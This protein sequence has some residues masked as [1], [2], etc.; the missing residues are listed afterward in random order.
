MIPLAMY[1][2]SGDELGLWYVFQSLGTAAILFDFGFNPSFA[3]NIAYCWSG[4]SSLSKRGG[5]NAELNEVNFV[6]LKK[7]LVTCRKIYLLIACSALFLCLTCGVGYIRFITASLNN[8]VYMTSWLIYSAAIFMN[9]YY[10]YFMSFLRGVGAIKQVNR[11]M[12]FARITQVSAMIILLVLGYGILAASVSYFLYGTLFRIIAQREFFSYQR[13]GIQLNSVENHF[14]YV[15]IWEMFHVIWYNTWRAGVVLF[16]NYLSN[17]ASTIIC[18]LFFTLAETGSY[19][20][21]VQLTSAVAIISSVAYTTY[22]PSLQA[23]YITGNSEKIRRDMSLIVVSYIM[24]FIIGIVALIVIGMPLFSMVK[25]DVVIDRGMLMFVGVYQFLIFF[26]NCYTSYLSCTNRLD[27][28][29]SFV[30]ASLICLPLSLLLIQSTLLGLW[31]LVTA[32]I[33]TQLAYNVWKWPLQVHRELNLRC[34]EMWR[35][36]IGEMKSLVFNR[37]RK[38]KVV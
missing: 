16:V 18:S 10:G 31:G 26:R 25:S 20:I 21:S 9:L 8:P 13:I 15:E 28:M 30:V 35:L 23:G 6:L 12:V 36:G 24:L 11:A 2:L 1:Y 4:A 14:S 19:S 22:Q 7:I 32:Q 38:G 29:T 34:G 3:R 37:K 27:Y 33:V 5:K 17:Q